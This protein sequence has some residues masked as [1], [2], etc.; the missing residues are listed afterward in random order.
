[1]PEREVKVFDDLTAL[2]RAAAEVVFELAN[3]AAAERGLFSMVLAGGGTPRKL[4]EILASDPFAV[5]MPW[6]DVHLFWG[7]ERFVP[8]ESPESN[9]GMVNRA[10]LE[11]VPIPAENVHPVRTT[12]FNTASEAAADY[13][14]E[15]EK[16]YSA[17]D[18]DSE[19]KR[20]N[21]PRLDL[22]LLGVGADG[23]TASLFPGGDEL[24]ETRK[25]A[26]AVR[27]PEN[28]ETTDRVSFSLPLI[29]NAANVLFLAGGRE[30]RQVLDA[31]LN[32]PNR[33]R[34]KYP[35]AMVDPADGRLIWFLDRE[36]A[37]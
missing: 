9:Y 10:M 31:V 22:V 2:S 19:S 3:R 11:Q 37:G 27:A 25:L 16:F 30:K 28:Y 5:K 33:A 14:T 8:P 1:M 36:A 32:D 15:V 20:W 35:A 24:A 34:E 7:D 18:N 17:N 12:Q 4:Y 13:G 6:K 29:N 23:H 21:F 26:V